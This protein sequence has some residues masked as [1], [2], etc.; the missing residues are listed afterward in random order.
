MS[1]ISELVEKLRVEAKSM[2]KYG[3]DYMATLLTRS[4]DTIEMLSEK[5]RADRPQEWIPCS[6]RLPETDNTNV[7]NEFDVLLAV[8][9]KK[10]PERTPQ[11]YIGK[12]RPV[13]GDDGSGNF[14][15]VKTAS[16]EWTIWGWSYFQEP[17]VLAWMPLP[18]PWKG[19]DDE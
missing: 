12:L 5:V 6:E 7:I 2:G 16:C 11:V 17:E 4:A 10:H 19:A 18:K 13:E 3:T 8:R 1:M 9:P 14:W 15:G